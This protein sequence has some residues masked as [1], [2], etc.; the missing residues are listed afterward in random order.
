MSGPRSFL[1]VSLSIRVRKVPVREAGVS[2]HTDAGPELWLRLSG[3]DG[4]FRIVGSAHTL[5]GRMLAESI[6]T[7]VGWRC[8]ILR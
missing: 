7:G 6:T 1:Q 5:V 2:D 4:L 8:P 3:S